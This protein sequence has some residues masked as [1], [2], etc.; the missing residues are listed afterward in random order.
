MAVS[1]E[2]AGQAAA[3]GDA[4]GHYAAGIYGS[5][6]VTALVGALR[7]AHAGIGDVTS[8]V[9]ATMTVF[10]LAHTWAQVQGERLHAG[11][12]LSFSHVRRIAGHEWPMLESGFAPVCALLLGW[13]GILDTTN[14]TRAALTIGIVQLLAWGFALGRRVYGTWHGAALAGLVDGAF[15]VGLVLLEIA[16]SH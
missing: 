8:T 14:A 16:V 4:A 12:H 2:P 13:V 3:H 11:H 5:I 1:E 10:W 7:E 15:G 6:V 9:I